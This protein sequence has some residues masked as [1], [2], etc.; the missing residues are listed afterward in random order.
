MVTGTVGG[1][2]NLNRAT[3]EELESLPGIG[4]KIAQRVVEYRQ[5]RGEFRRPEDL[6][7]VPGIGEKKLA[8]LRPLI[9]L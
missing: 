5:T 8:A 3:A 4:P 9:A 1:R 6:L 7:N 2:V